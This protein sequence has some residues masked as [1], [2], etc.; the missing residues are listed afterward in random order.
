MICANYRKHYRPIVVFVCLHITIPRYHN[1]EDVSESIE[2]LKCLSDASVECVSKIKSILS[3]IRH[4]IYGAV[5]IQFAH[6]SND[7]C[8][9][10][11]TLSYYHH[12]I[13]SMVHCHFKGLCHKMACAVCFSVLFWEKLLPAK[14][15]EMLE[16]LIFKTVLVIPQ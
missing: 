7:Y 4:V 5:C 8:E 15:W 6:I 10:T 1:F 16:S 11:C 12:Q 14:L 9:N 13:G 2:L 3:I